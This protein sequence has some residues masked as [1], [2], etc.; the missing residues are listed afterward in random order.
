M[1]QVSGQGHGA[2]LML[3]GGAGRQ[4]PKSAEVVAA[5]LAALRQI[6]ANR[7]YGW[8]ALAAD[9]GCDAPHLNGP[10]EVGYT[11]R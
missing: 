7:A 11:I 4:T 1:R 8:I 9:G 6:A 3:H 2:V 10:P 5:S